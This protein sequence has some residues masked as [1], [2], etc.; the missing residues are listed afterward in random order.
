MPQFGKPYVLRTVLVMML[1]AGIALSCSEKP[2]PKTEESTPLKHSLARHFDEVHTDDLSGMVKRGYIRV[3]VTLNRTNFFITDGEM[4]GYEYS[5]LNEYERDLQSRFGKT[6]VA[7]DFIPV[8]RD[9]LIPKLVEGY[10]DIAAAGLTVTP[11]RSEKVRFT[12]PYLTG[13]D[14]VVVVNRSV[15]GIETP[16]DLSGRE[17]F[18]RESSSYHESLDKLNR[19][20]VEEGLPPAKIIPAPETL[21]TEDILEM[22]NTGAVDI[23]VA[24]SHIAEIW[25]QALDGINVLFGVKLRHGGRIAWAVRKGSPKLAA[26]ID[27]FMDGHRK[28]TL[29][30][31][32][33]FERYWVKNEWINNPLEVVD[34]GEHSNKVELF[35]KYGKEYDFD[36]MLLMATAYQESGWNNRIVSPAGAVG[37]MQIRPATAR[38][39]N[40]GID[41]MKSLDGNIHAGTKYLAF[42]RDRYFSGDGLDE[43]DRVRF[44]LAAYNAGPARVEEARKLAARMGLDPDVWFHNVELAM[45]K[46][47]GRQPVEYVEN[48]N[49][50]YI[51]FRMQ[52]HQSHLREKEKENTV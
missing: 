36:W 33:Y 50:Y 32:I 2:P 18:V 5:L 8:N 52:D 19:K 25:S 47:A 21:E 1:V 11:E 46:V 35:R 44:T 4:K 17:V 39:P 16:E 45:L 24:D 27:T 38:D 6:K 40:V 42:L 22:V 31:N 7:L 28:G 15:K 3:L 37:I 13:V 20:L 29:L 26:D 14:E 49:K 9:E 30:G 48:I 34:N 23:T 10:G 43:A 41:G 12:A 51:I